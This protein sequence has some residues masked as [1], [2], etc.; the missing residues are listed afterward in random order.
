MCPQQFSPKN[1]QRLKTTKNS[2][3]TNILHS[4]CNRSPKD[5]HILPSIKPDLYDVVEQGKQWCQRERSHKDGHKTILDN[6]RWKLR[7]P[8]ICEATKHTD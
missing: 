8:S 7:K 1:T 5:G 4:G 2:L 3:F 6:Y